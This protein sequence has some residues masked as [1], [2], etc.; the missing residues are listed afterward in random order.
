MKTEEEVAREKNKM[1]KKHEK[2][3]DLR[4]VEPALAENEPSLSADYDP[5]G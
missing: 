1:T 5:R 4:M 3:R 2:E